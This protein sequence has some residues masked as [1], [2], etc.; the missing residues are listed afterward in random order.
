MA[1]SGSLVHAFIILGKV[2]NA[3]NE[4]VYL[5][6]EGYTPAQLIHIINNAG[7]DINPWYKLSTN[8][9]EIVI[10]SYTLDQRISD[11]S[12]YMTKLLLGCYFTIKST[13]K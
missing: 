2:M 3:N 9:M 1:N 12:C 10:A 6:A 13:I 7:M 11:N 5:L 4:S 8:Y